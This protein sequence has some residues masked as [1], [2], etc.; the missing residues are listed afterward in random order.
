MESFL[1]SQS[2]NL[3]LGVENAILVEVWPI[4]DES[5]SRYFE[6]I[7]FQLIRFKNIQLLPRRGS[8]VNEDIR[9]RFIF[10]YLLR[11][12]SVADAIHSSCCCSTPI[13]FRF[14][15]AHRRHSYPLQPTLR[16]GLVLGSV[17]TSEFVCNWWRVSRYISNAGALIFISG[18]W[19]NGI[20][21]Y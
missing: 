11:I 19:H 2:D 12:I 8:P 16:F 18:I 17:W 20:R 7:C 6:R 3:S 5:G 4:H 13:S 1:L 9:C 14:L 21:G 15:V 10:F